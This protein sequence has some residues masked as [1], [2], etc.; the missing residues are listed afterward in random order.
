MYSVYMHT[1]PN[2]KVYVGITGRN[3]VNRWKN[4]NGYK[5]SYFHKAIQKYGWANI[6]HEI[7]YSGLTKAEAAEIEVRLISEH[8]SNL[9]EYGYN[10]SSGGECGRAGAVASEETRR[11][12]SEAHKNHCP[13]AETRKKMSDSRRGFVISVEHKRA[14]IESR[15][16]SHHTEAARQKIS[17]KLKGK[18][19]WNRRPVI[20]I[21]TGERFVSCAAAGDALGINP[22]CISYACNGKQKTAGK[23]R[24]M[25]DV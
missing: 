19:A 17:E 14:L 5:G 23:L 10:I 25:F 21:D 18:P 20:C 6:K 7:V 12:L 16:G 4:G 8:K 2:G 15:R 24:W 1:C 3:P 9:R 22:D 13:T 11:R